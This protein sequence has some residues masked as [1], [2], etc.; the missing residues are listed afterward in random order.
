MPVEPRPG[1]GAP[2][3]L[4]VTLSVPPPWAEAV[5]AVAAQLAAE[6]DLGPPSPFAPHV[7]LCRPF[8]CDAAPEAVA[9]VVG[10]ALPRPPL[11]PVR[12]GG[13]SSFRMSVGSPEVIYVAVRA[14]WLGL[15]NRRLV[16]ET[17]PYRCGAEVLLAVSGNPEYDLDDY[18]PHITVVMERGSTVH[19][20]PHARR[21]ALAERSATL[22]TQ[23]RPAGGGFAVEEI[24]L[25]VLDA[26]GADWPPPHAAPLVVRTWRFGDTGPEELQPAG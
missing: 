2:V 20:A 7:S 22:W 9:H 18:T 26:D 13:I 5:S 17:E 15:L 16:Q 11:T 1:Q 8:C 4:A 10:A 23:R 21:R 3:A 14:R 25:S 24:V 6:F 12:V 19:P